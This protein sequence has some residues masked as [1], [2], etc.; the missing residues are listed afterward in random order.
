MV[1]TYRAG[2]EHI[3]AQSVALLNRCRAAGFGGA[4]PADLFART[5]HGADRRMWRVTSHVDPRR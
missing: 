3:R 5:S 1:F 4:G 2:A